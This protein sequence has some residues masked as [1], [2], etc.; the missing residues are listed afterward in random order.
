MY[1]GY[2]HHCG[3]H[4]PARNSWRLSRRHTGQ[5]QDDGVPPDPATE[6]AK[7]Q[8]YY[9]STYQGVP[10][11]TPA[12]YANE[13]VLNAISAN[14]FNHTMIDFPTT[15]RTTP[16]VKFFDPDTGEE[17]YAHKSGTNEKVPVTIII[18]GQDRV[19]FGSSGLTVG[20]DY[21]LHYTASAEF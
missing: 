8:R 19:N 14:R 1:N 9:Y 10:A 11:G 15:M 2:R 20:V 21:Y 17:G 3:R 6:L 7:C 13:L 18:A 4:L 12:S 5:L 16:T